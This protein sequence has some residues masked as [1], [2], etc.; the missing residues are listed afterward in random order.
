MSD[1]DVPADGAT[2]D[3]ADGSDEGP[4]A[5]PF[6]AEVDRARDLLDGE[7]IEAV[8]VGVVRDGEVD[9]TF[10]QRGDGDAENEGLRALALLAAHV[11][12][13]ANEAGVD[14]STVAGDAATLAG[15]VE[16]VPTNTDDLP[17]E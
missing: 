10:A 4:D 17:E 6:A 2:A 13:V 5:G 1:D 12:L 15:Q 9:T 16:R 7:G 8:H 3:D 11:R 14:A